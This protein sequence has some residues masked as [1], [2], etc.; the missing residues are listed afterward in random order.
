MRRFCMI[1]EH[2][3]IHIASSQ[4]HV[5]ASCQALANSHFAGARFTKSFLAETT[6]T[7]SL[8]KT[9]TRKELHRDFDAFSFYPPGQSPR[10][11]AQCCILAQDMGYVLL[12][13][14]FAEKQGI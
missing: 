4:T 13:S 2:D 12:H 5:S 1:D 11:T 9:A 10:K 14:L 3:T 8:S 6:P 7:L